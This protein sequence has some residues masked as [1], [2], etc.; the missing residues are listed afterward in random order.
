MWVMRTTLHNKRSGTGKL[1]VG[2]LNRA[3]LQDIYWTNSSAVAECRLK[4]LKR[5]CRAA[6]GRNT[7]HMF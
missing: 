7:F 1:Y 6:I 5:R 3:R 2:T 4:G